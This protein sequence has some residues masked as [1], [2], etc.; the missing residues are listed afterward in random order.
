MPGGRPLHTPTTPSPGPP[1]PRCH[2]GAMV[3]HRP[4]A[5]MEVADTLSR[6]SLSAKARP[7]SS[8]SAPNPPTHCYP[9]T[10]I[11]GHPHF[12]SNLARLHF[13]GNRTHTQ[14]PINR[15]R[16]AALDR[17]RQG[18]CPATHRNYVSC[19][20]LYVHF[21]DVYSILLDDPDQQDIEFLVLGELHLATI[22]NYMSAVKALYVWWDK[23]S[24]IKTFSSRAL[25][26]S[27]RGIANTVRPMDDHRSAV[28]LQQLCVMLHVCETR[29]FT[30]L[31]IAICLAFYAYVRISNLAPASARQFNPSI[32]KLRWSKMRQH[33]V[34][35]QEIPI[36]ALHDPAMALGPCTSLHNTPLLQSTVRGNLVMVTTS[37]L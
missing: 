27:L 20:S 32:F 4:C 7:D 28:T 8:S 36:A 37:H 1:H 22:K 5:Q 15:L 10:F 16:Q 18:L 34:A 19:V 17:R 25:S 24:A 30:T 14:S 6:A 9:S 13:P 11:T 26:M 21:C 3:Y 2:Q 29:Q 33:L 35:T 12:P 31:A 23:P